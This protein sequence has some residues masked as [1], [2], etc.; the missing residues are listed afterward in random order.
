MEMAA[1]IRKKTGALR[2]PLANYRNGFWGGSFMEMAA[3]IRKLLRDVR[4]MLVGTALLLGAFQCLW[5]KI[6]ERIVGQLAP[7]VAGLAR[8]GGLDLRDVLEKIFEGEGQVVRT[9]IGG[10]GIAPDN[11]MD[12]LSIGYVHPLMQTI[13]CIWAIGRA[14]GAIAGEIDRGTMELLLAQP[15]ARWRLVLAHFLVD[16]ITIPLLCL[17]LWAGNGVGAWLVG[18]EIRVK[19]LKVAAP[20]PAYLVELGPLKVRIEGPLDRGPAPAPSPGASERLRVRPAAFGPALW[21]V[22][23][24]VFAVSGATLWLSAAGRFRW[25][26]LG[27]AVFFFLLQFLVN[28]VG[29]MWEPA[30]PLRPLTIFYYYQPQEVILDQDWTVPLREWNGGKPLCLVP[31]PA[32]LYGVGAVGYLMAAWTF[33]RRDLPAPL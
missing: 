1:L 21:V 24:L 16:A 13:L 22:G 14:A 18:P 30:E 20:R 10:E 28:V 15:L 26:V 31:M 32:V 2:P 25:R 9:L 6:T 8:L 29:Q 7:L 11:A 5:A 23:G 12:M 3:L 33:S 27:I 17:S 19:P 4:L